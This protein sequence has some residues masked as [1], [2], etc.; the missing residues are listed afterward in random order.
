MSEN[1]ACREAFEI[2]TAKR[3]YNYMLCTP[4]GRR[5][6]GQ[7]YEHNETE[8]AYRFWKLAWLTSDAHQKAHVN[9][10]QT[11]NR[12]LVNALKRIRAI[13]EIESS[14]FS[15]ENSRATASYLVKIIDEEEPDIRTSQS[16]ICALKRV[17]DS[18]QGIADITSDCGKS[19]GK[20]GSDW[21]AARCGELAFILSLIHI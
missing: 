5:V 16:D 13:S 2:S 20:E 12:K 9:E 8:N 7:T 17:R 14:T 10:L 18:L 1:K 6:T 11:Y 21:I 4:E 3:E 19:E 15:K